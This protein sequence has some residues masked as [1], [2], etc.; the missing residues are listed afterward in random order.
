MGW[1]MRLSVGLSVRLGVSEVGTSLLLLL[2]KCLYCV[3]W[4]NVRH[5]HPC[6]ERSKVKVSEK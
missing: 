2:N 5:W 1:S 6:M 4:M 3:I